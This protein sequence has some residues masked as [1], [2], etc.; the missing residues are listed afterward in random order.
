[1]ID[2]IQPM[3]V[4]WTFFGCFARVHKTVC[5]EAQTSCSA[6]WSIGSILTVA[7]FHFSVCEV[8]LLSRPLKQ[9]PD[10]ADLGP[11][12]LAY[13]DALARPEPVLEI[14]IASAA[15]AAGAFC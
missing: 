6:A 13:L 9:R 12:G 11:H 3:P 8:E 2:I 15:R 10:L 14:A 5:C 1:M 4:H 7:R